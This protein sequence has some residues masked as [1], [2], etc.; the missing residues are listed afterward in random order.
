MASTDVL[1]MDNRHVR[2]MKRF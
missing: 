2:I 1:R